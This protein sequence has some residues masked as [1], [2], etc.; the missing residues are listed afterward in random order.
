MGG[1]SPARPRFGRSVVG[2]MTT[3]DCLHF[4]FQSRLSS[5]KNLRKKD[6]IGYNYSKSRF[7]MC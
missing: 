2:S 6:E 7:T 1:M 3:H 5:H 4:S